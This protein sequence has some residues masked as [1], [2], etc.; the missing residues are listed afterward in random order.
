MAAPKKPLKGPKQ[1]AG[2]AVTLTLGFGAKLKAKAWA[3][4]LELA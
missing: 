4:A 1:K 2:K 3:A